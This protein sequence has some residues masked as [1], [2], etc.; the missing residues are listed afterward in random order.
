[1]YQSI[2]EYY[3][4]SSRKL[5]KKNLIYKYLFIYKLNNKL[6]LKVPNE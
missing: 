3:C 5:K 2:L 1:M 6:P 4:E